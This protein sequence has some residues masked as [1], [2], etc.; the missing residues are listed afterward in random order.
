MTS[1]SGQ[2]T[3]ADDTTTA[4]AAYARLR[5]GTTLLWQGDFHNGRQLIRAVDR[6]LTKQAARKGKKKQSAGTAADLFLRQRE[7]RA[8]RAEILGRIVVDLAE[9]DGQW[10]LD[11]HRAPDVAGACGHAYGAPSRGES[12]RTPFTALQGVLGAYQWH[13]NGVEVPALG[14]KVYPDYGVFSPTRSEYVD[15]VDDVAAAFL[16]SLKAGA[17][18]LELGTGTGVLAA[19]LARRGA[20]RVTATD[21]NPRAVA[22]ARANLDRLGVGERCEV[23]EADLWPAVSETTET[24]DAADA[25][26]AADI[27][28]FN[29]PWLPGTPTS[30]LELG[31][32]D[33]SSDAL[34]R[35]LTEVTDHLTDGGEGWLV[36]SDLAEH[37]GLRTREQL[38]TWISD[39]GLQVLGRSDTT[40]RH[41]KVLRGDDPLH[42]AR[43]REVTSL[44][45]LGRM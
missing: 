9:R 28:V 41:P 24:T 26:D 2:T 23:V 5:R 44:W 11:L 31:I 36:L 16:P 19:V 10:L 25:A 20:V 18:V 42:V 22:C 29:P 4:D 6:R 45:R 39:G 17:S 38:E 7:D 35:F 8:R 3:V 30:E 13:L 21:V 1:T 32:Y 40:P 15:L 43:S 12:R 27:V 33:A 14:E 37:L 34:R